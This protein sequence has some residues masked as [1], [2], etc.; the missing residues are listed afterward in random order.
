MAAATRQVAHDTDCDLIAASYEERHGGLSPAV[1]DLFECELDV[2]V[3]RSA[4]GRTDWITRHRSSLADTS[5]ARLTK[6]RQD[7]TINIKN[8]SAGR[9]EAVIDADEL[10]VAVVGE[11]LADS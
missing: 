11:R 4:G 9:R 8:V 1:R 7:Q 10:V 5:E 3:H 6:R 2:L